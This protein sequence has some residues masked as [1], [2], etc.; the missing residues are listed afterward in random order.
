[1]LAIVSLDAREESVLKL[2]PKFCLSTSLK[3]V[4][5]LALVRSVA[6]A[7]AEL[8]RNHFVGES[9]DAVARPVDGR[10]RWA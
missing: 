3:T 2:G 10:P 6:R 4:E 1:M 5:Q 9:V 7:V 8:E